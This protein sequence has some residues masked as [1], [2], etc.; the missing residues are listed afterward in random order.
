MMYLA[1]IAGGLGLALVFMR[2]IRNKNRQIA[3]LKG[4]ISEMEK[5][6]GSAKS[7]SDL[8]RMYA[9]LNSLWVE[10][11][12][13]TGHKDQERQRF[14]DEFDRALKRCHDTE[15]SIKTPDSQDRTDIN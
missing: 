13:V 8:E 15:A 6:I 10:F 9:E 12:S 11:E 4:S 7:C 1:A 3:S 14:T 2:A 5:D